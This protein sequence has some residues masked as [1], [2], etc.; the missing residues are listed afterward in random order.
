[1][2]R[3]KAQQ[4]ARLARASLIV[5]SVMSLRRGTHRGWADRRYAK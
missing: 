2:R 5:A 4:Q 1:M 3:S